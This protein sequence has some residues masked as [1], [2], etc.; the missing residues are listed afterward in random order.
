MDHFAEKLIECRRKKD[1]TQDALAAALN[2]SRTTV[3]SWE[4][5]R[6]EPD[7]ASLRRLSQLL[8][9][10]FLQNQTLDS[11]ESVPDTP[12]EADMPTPED[13]PAVAPSP[14]GTAAR[15][16]KRWLIIGAALLVCAALICAAFLLL[17]PGRSGF[18]AEQY[19]KETANDPDRA[20]LSFYNRMWEENTGGS[21]YSCYNFTLTERNGKPFNV[22]R[23][24]ANMESSRNKGVKTIILAAGDLRS[25]GLEPD[26]PAYGTLSI[27]GGYPK[28]VYD[29]V[30]I[31]AYGKDADGTLNAFYTLIEF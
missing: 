29:R 15:A 6:T 17:R 24:E 2:V 16:K 23:I 27:N 22:D 11:L 30:G 20:Y 26:I 7:I 1:L 21:T 9:Y 31:I 12:Q 18:D 8:D 13:A 4:R 28:G 10:D 25:F 14:K 5:G 19:R 3:S